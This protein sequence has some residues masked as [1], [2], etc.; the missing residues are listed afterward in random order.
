MKLTFVSRASKRI[1]DV[2][3]AGAVTLWLV[4][5][6]LPA[7]TPRGG[8]SVPGYEILLKGFEATDYGVFAWLANPLFWIAVVF[9]ALRR[10]RAALAVAALSLFFAL[11]SFAAAPL[12]RR[13][14]GPTLELVFEVGFFIWLGAPTLL[15]GLAGILV[16]R[17]LHARGDSGGGAGNARD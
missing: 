9:A 17:Q 3:I 6:L 5:L 7:V 10:Y 4:S 11:Q 2:A 8:R 13:Q 14:G 16:W 15:G 1:S 12:A